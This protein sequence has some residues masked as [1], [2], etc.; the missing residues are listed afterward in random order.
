LLS[1]EGGGPAPPFAG[2]RV[3][4]PAAPV[5]RPATGS[6]H[7]RGPAHVTHALAAGRNVPHPRRRDRRAFLTHATERTPEESP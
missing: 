5:P 4:A 6:G 1:D 2:G 3:P 7:R